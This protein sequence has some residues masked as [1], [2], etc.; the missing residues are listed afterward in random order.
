MGVDFE[1]L[2]FQRFEEYQ[3]KQ[4]Q[5]KD[6]I[7]QMEEE[8]ANVCTEYFEEIFKIAVTEAIRANVGFNLEVFFAS[9]QVILSGE[10]EGH[11]YCFTM[12]ELDNGE[13]GWNISSRNDEGVPSNREY[14]F[15]DLSRELLKIMGRY[16]AMSEAESEQSADDEIDS[17][18]DLTAEKE[19]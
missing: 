2:V 8:I 3:A 17:D 18:A 5:V 15:E 6:L 10:H 16:E 11:A 4:K 1:Q 7:K 13:I 14:P 9:P 19:E 12:A